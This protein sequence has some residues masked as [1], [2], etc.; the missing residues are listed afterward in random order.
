L[1]RTVRDAEIAHDPIRFR[2]LLELRPP[3]VFA[4]NLEDSKENG[5]TG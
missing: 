2:I 1:F 4:A 3:L 5:E